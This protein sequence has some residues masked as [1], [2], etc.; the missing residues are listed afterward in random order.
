MK[1]SFNTEKET[2]WESVY[3]E[4]FLHELNQIIKHLYSATLIFKYM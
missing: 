4:W 2:T 1:L 3:Q